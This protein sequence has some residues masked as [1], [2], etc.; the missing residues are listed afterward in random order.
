MLPTVSSITGSNV[1]V[2]L[3]VR[4]LSAKERLIGSSECIYAVPGIPQVIANGEK[5]FL[6]DTVLDQNSTQKSIFEECVLPLMDKFIQGYNITILAYGQTG[7]GKTFTMGT[8]LEGAVNEDFL[9]IIPRAVGFI[10]NYLYQEQ[11]KSGDRSTSMQIDST[12][13][14]SA[15]GQQQKD[16]PSSFEM[17]VSFL[18]IYNEDIIDLLSPHSNVIKRPPLM[19]RED[20]SGEIYLAGLKEEPISCSEDIF[21][22]LKKGTLCRT[23][24][25]TD[26]NLNSSRSHAIF[27]L[28]L[29]QVKSDINQSIISK[30]HFV[31]LAGSERLKKT[32]AIGS[33][34]KE[35]ISIN[36]GLL[37]LGNVIS[38]LSDDT[39]RVKHI[40]YRN[41][42]LTRL[43]QDSLGGNSHTVMIACVSPSSDNYSETLSTLNY[44][45]RARNIR[46]KAVIN[47][48]SATNS[49]FEISQ[50]KKQISALKQEI[51]LVR[52]HASHLEDSD[53]AVLQRQYDDLMRE[54]IAIEIERDNLL[55]SS[56]GEKTDGNGQIEGYVRTINELRNKINDLE[57]VKPI[58]NATVVSTA[59]SNPFCP[60]TPAGMTPRKRNVSYSIHDLD[61][62]CQS[63]VRV[64]DLVDRLRSKLSDIS[65]LS[66]KSQRFFQFGESIDSLGQDL[67]GFFADESTCLEELSGSIDQFKKEYASMKQK[68]EEKIKQL[69]EFCYQ[70]QMQRD[71]AIKQRTQ[72]PAQNELTRVARGRYE[73]KIRKLNAE[74]KDSKDK[75]A[76]LQR[77]SKAKCSSND[78]LVK[79]LKASLEVTKNERNKLQHRLTE[80][81]NKKSNRDFDVKEAKNKEKRTADLLI[82]WKKAFELQKEILAKRNDQVL[83][84]KKRIKSLLQQCKTNKGS[85]GDERAVPVASPLASH[86]KN[87]D[88]LD[89]KI[90]SI[91]DD[92]FTT[93]EDLTL[94]LSVE[95]ERIKDLVGK[96]LKE[97]EISSKIMHT[98]ISPLKSPQEYKQ[99]K[100]LEDKKEVLNSVLTFFSNPSRI[101]AV[102]DDTIKALLK[103]KT[104]SPFEKRRILPC[105]H[106][107]IQIQLHH[108][109][110]ELKQTLKRA[111]EHNNDETLN[112]SPF[113]L[114]RKSF[115]M[116][117]TL[118]NTNDSQVK[119]IDEYERDTVVQ[120]GS[121]LKNEIMQNDCEYE[122]AQNCSTF[123][124]KMTDDCEESLDAVSQME[125]D[126]S[127]DQL[128]STS[129]PIDFSLRPICKLS[130]HVGSVL[131]VHIIEDCIFS[132]S[133]DGTIKQWSI[134]NQSFVGNFTT[135]ND[136]VM[137]MKSY[138]KTSLFATTRN[139]IK[140]WDIRSGEC[141]ATLLG[142]TDDVQSLF[143]LDNCLF[144][145]SSDLTT[146]VWDL[147]M[148]LP[149]GSLLGHKGAIHSICAIPE[150]DLVFTGSR[151][152]TIRIYNSSTLSH[153]CTIETGH[154]DSLT[155]ITRMP[156]EDCILS[157]ARD[158]SLKKWQISGDQLEDEL[159][160]VDNILHL[161]QIH[162]NWITG[163]GVVTSEENLFPSAIITA[164][165]AGKVKVWNES[166]IP[167][168]SSINGFNLHSDKIRSIE[169]KNFINSDSSLLVT[170]SDDT[171]IGLC[172]LTASNSSK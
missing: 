32:N 134:Q 57:R 68:Y 12:F 137:A 41:S 36:S 142:H 112:N 91:D 59:L 85:L 71:E 132:S 88:S 67:V 65:V 2:A 40:P 135:N 61:T 153:R 11:S 43:L 31:D 18:E 8:G 46:N 25:S 117:Q 167:T 106:H 33:R 121:E 154:L 158:C 140:R 80:E 157:V 79:N 115:N 74:L 131:D 105:F 51:I 26:M 110:F 170:G 143:V 78:L 53:V 50:L 164:D 66:E 48:E 114:T 95:I 124:A 49:A 1:K 148:N 111:I 72:P 6:Y 120:L 169:S 93:E 63:G 103:A 149:M 165:L 156:R 22:L 128:Q 162:P 45:S 127:L 145:G 42:K 155:R 130:G 58:P 163:L 73:E 90:L 20:L 27:T 166:F 44:A 30:I 83:Y 4:P 125:E 5:S 129:L 118:A 151:D 21:D 133:L 56:S 152:N 24:G 37:A 172:Q 34:V 141:I 96:E 101:D 122:L 136:F 82:Q 64:S 9:G 3:R 19:I 100:H 92:F 70:A 84:A 81:I 98:T 10:F 87:S 123:L 14:A 35:S 108:T 47:Q 76:M 13:D 75:A 171:T 39:S 54:K 17:Y 94:Y 69:Q 60:G 147:R 86:L 104:N 168:H 160:C 77:Q 52:N 150:N 62:V 139:E 161:P 113:K 89:E 38:A 126:D 116:E 16:I 102:V 119:N 97:L 107:I 138:E 144:S 99:S 109:I 146:M 23:T 15:S 159:I 55:F 29:R 28:V 7:S